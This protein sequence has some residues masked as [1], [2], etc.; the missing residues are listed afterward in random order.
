MRSSSE[1]SFTWFFLL[2]RFFFIIIISN[3]SL[4]HFSLSFTCVLLQKKMTSLC[5]EECLNQTRAGEKKKKK[6]RE[7]R[8][9]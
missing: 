2:F 3:L 1:G 4:I 7:K 5:G 6:K 8:E 9:S